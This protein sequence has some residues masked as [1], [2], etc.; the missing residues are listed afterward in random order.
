LP[1]YFISLENFMSDKIYKVLFLCTGNSARSIMA[2]AMLN[3]I[4]EG[5]FIAYS[6]GSHPAGIVN[7]LAIEQVEQFG[8]S[9]ENLRSKNWN[10]FS[11]DTAPQMDFVITV[12]DKAAGEVCPFWPG[13]PITAHWGFQDPANVNGS[14]E[15]KRNAFARVCREI[16][17][18]LDLF[19]SLPIEK[20]ERLALK[21]ELEKIGL[22]SILDKP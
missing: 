19:L 13:Q 10:E 5:R 4:G 1:I 17:T 18:R 3:V 8:Y 14:V 12:C 21:S 7:T 22:S 11:L 6:A 15:E 2:E 20:I 16:K 9:S